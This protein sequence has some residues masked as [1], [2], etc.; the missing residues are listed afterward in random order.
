MTWF[1]S[2]VKQTNSRQ[3]QWENE[4]ERR[5]GRSLR[6]LGHATEVH[7]ISPWVNFRIAVVDF[8]IVVL[9]IQ[10]EGVIADGGKRRR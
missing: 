5:E 4:Q 8:V 6:Y 10:E 1:L 9:V 7:F 3:Q 2:A